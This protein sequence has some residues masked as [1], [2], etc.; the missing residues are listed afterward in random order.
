MLG[1]TETLGS[2]LLRAEIAG[3]YE[4]LERR[5][6]D[7]RRR[8]QR[9]ALPALLGARAPGRSRGRVVARLPVALRPRARAGR[10]GGARRAASG[11][12]LGAR[13]RPN[14][15]R[16][17]ARRRAPWSS[18][19]RTTRPACTR[20]RRSSTSSS[21]LV[22][23]HGATLVCDEVYR[24]LE[25][26]PADRLPAAADSSARA[27]SV[28]VLSKSYALAGLRVGWLATRNRELLDA[29]AQVR[30]YTSLCSPAPSE[31]LGIDRP[32]RRRGAGRA[33]PRHHRGQ[34]AARGR[35]AGRARR[36]ARLGAP[37]G[38]LDRLS[39]LPRRRGHRRVQRAPRARAGRAA[40]CRAGCT[41]TA[42][43]ASASASA[44]R[45]LPEAVERLDRQLRA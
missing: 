15:R 11:G 38:R 5:R 41:A 2:P 20:A 12:R 30:D 24:G 3:L 27:V 17:A 23:S 31:V 28:G 18:T 22:E 35:A 10:R 1:Y 34:P 36:A 6:H 32:A 45:N 14:R 13:P 25:Q 33:Q 16:P 37:D 21:E 42:T 7:R 39:A 44:A 4:T 19:S 43:G 8:G 9:G 40:C 26:E 29:V